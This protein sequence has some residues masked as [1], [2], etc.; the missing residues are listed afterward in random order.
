MKLTLVILAVPVVLLSA[1]SATEPTLDRGDVAGFDDEV[2]RLNAE[3]FRTPVDSLP[4]GT[5]NYDGQIGANILI[6]GQSGFAILGDLDLDVGFSGSRDVDGRVTD[7]N[8]LRAGTPQQTLGGSLDVT[9]QQASGKID[10]VAEGV[11]TRV[12]TGG[13]DERTNLVLDLDGTVRTDRFAADTI[14]GTVNADRSFGDGFDINGPT[15][16]VVLDGD[17]AFYAED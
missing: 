4:S 8:L 13:I 7:I 15:F 11:L 12:R 9:G 17:G 6:D 10:A 1:C 2:A 3:A 14:L 16:N 5:V